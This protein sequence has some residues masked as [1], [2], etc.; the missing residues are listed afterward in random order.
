M[1]SE[2]ITIAKLCIH[3]FGNFENNSV[4][5]KKYLLYKADTYRLRS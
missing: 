3:T 1:L 5:Y 2:F 4:I